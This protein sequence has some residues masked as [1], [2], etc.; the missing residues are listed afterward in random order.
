MICHKSRES[1]GSKKRDCKGRFGKVAEENETD[2]V[3]EQKSNRS[4]SGEAC[5]R[6]DD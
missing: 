6:A 2:D 3:R 4:S 1:A 5:S